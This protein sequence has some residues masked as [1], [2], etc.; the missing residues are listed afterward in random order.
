MVEKRWLSKSQINTFLQCPRKWKY[1]YE[2]GISSIPSSQM[3]RGTKIHKKVEEFYKNVNIKDN[4]VISN[5][6]DLKKF[7]DFENQRLKDCP[8]MKYY[9]PVFQELRVVNEELGLRGIIDAIF[10]NPKDGQLIIIDWKTG[11]AKNNIDEY[12]L[13][14]AIYKILFE[15]DKHINKVEGL[16]VGYWGI[17]FLDKGKLL[18][19]PVNDKYVQKAIKIINKV[20]LDIE[21]KDY[22]MKPSF[23]CR[24]CQFKDKCG[25]N[26][27][28]I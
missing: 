11:Q 25:G 3:L 20:R 18:F 10:I 4:K 24:Y 8:D 6:V 2:D 27:V 16:N 21:K 14:L 7:V 1:I 19:E 13:E 12:R 22:K 23:W 15:N 5:D 9:K 28:N 17:F 26:N